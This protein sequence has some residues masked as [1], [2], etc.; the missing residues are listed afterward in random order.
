MGD[1]TIRPLSF[2]GV[3]DAKQLKLLTFSLKRKICNIREP[4]ADP[5]PKKKFRFD[6]DIFIEQ[7][8]NSAIVGGIAGIAAYR[9]DAS[10]EAFAIGFALA[11]LIKLKEYRKIE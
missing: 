9:A 11:F 10:L 6:I 8:L 3:G 4:K 5:K 2:F 7:V 1:H